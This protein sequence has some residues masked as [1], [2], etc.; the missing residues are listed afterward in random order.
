MNQRLLLTVLSVSGFVGLCSCKTVPK[1]LSDDRTPAEWARYLIHNAV[2]V[3]LGTLSTQTSIL[4]YPFISVRSISDGPAANS[5][6]IPY[7][8]MPASGITTN[9]LEA[10]NR[11]TIMATQS[12]DKLCEDSDPQEPGCAK[13]FITGTHVKVHH[14]VSKLEI[15]QIELLAVSEGLKHITVEEYFSASITE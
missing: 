5:T 7:F 14:F 15:T 12:Q 1:T 2:W 8:Y 13:V 4:G 9:D 11:V 3:S 6:G 10:D